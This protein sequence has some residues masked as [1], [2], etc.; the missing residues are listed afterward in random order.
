MNHQLAVESTDSCTHYD[1]QLNRGYLHVLG[2]L[3][4]ANILDVELISR[5]RPNDFTNSSTE[6]TARLP[7]LLGDLDGLRNKGERMY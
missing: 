7:L 6:S 2:I 4:H 1:H 3:A 5:M